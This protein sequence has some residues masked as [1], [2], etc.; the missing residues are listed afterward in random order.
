MVDPSITKQFQDA[1]FAHPYCA[2][3][4]NLHRNLKQFYSQWKT[5]S[6]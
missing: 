6:I 5:E 1:D 3:E 2:S 4:T